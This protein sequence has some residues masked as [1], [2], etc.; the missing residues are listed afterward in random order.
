M[1]E[2]RT[3]SR[4]LLD[5]ALAECRLGLKGRVGGTTVDDTTRACASTFV[6]AAR[7]LNVPP[8]RV[9]VIFKNMILE[10][11][12]VSRLRADERM[13]TTRMFVQ[14]A[15]DVYYEAPTT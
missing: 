12:E 5:A 1:L 4:L 3:A 8:E 13:E 11:P 15:I 10:L 2:R 14:I 6:N 7:K 9:L